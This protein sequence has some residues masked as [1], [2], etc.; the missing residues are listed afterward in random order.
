METTITPQPQ[1][2]VQHTK[3]CSQCAQHFLTHSVWKKTCDTCY[4]TKNKTL[5][6]TNNEQRRREINLGQAKN[7]AFSLLLERSNITS[8]KLEDYE[9]TFLNDVKIINQWLTKIDQQNL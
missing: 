9:T 5:P 6:Y 1:Q 3:K 8:N 2:T 7:L 4:N